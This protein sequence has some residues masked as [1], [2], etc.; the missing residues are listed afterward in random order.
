MRKINESGKEPDSQ[1]DSSPLD[2]PEM[3]LCPV[4]KRL[5]ES[6]VLGTLGCGLELQYSNGCVACSLNERQELLDT[7]ARF[8]PEDESEDSI[9]VLRKLAEF[10]DTHQG[11]GRVVV[12]YPAPVVA[13]SVG[14]II[15]GEYSLDQLRAMPTGPCRE[16]NDESFHML[17]C[18]LNRPNPEKW[19]KDRA[20]G[21][22]SP[23]LADERRY[24]R[25]EDPS[26]NS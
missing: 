3:P 11:E 23:V 15:A 2:A 1:P 21:A 17:D 26:P 4:H 6:G 12:S 13:D 24:W 25:N 19:S 18:S 14:D 8:A 7:L 16:C 5:N 22:C 9:A 20:Y 10:W